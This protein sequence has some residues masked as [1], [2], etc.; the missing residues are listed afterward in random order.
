MN[1]VSYRIPLQAITVIAAADLSSKQYYAVKLNADGEAALAGAGENAVGI[2]Q[3][4]PAEDQA[5]NV[6]VLGESFAVC[7]GNIVAGSNLTPDAQGRLVTAGGA[8]CVIAVAREAGALNE[9]HTVL[10]VTRTAT[11]TTGVASAPSILVIPVTL[12]SLD[13]VNAMTAYTPGFAGS[14]KKLSFLVTTPTT[15]VADCNCVVSLLIGAVAV[16]GGVLTLDVDVAG[17]DPDTLGK[18]VDATA[19]TATNAFAAV[20]TISIVVAN[21]ANPFTVGAGVLLLVIEK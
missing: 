10:L 18:V 9:V 17:T 16:T 3:D 4:T 11:G 1:Q 20:D 19:I 7:G 5:G 21:T 8:D 15:D 14:L 2:L 12:A 6:M 13:D